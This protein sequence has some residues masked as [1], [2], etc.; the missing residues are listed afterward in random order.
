MSDNEVASVADA[1]GDVVLGEAEAIEWGAAETLI[2][3]AGFCQRVTVTNTT[4]E[5]ITWE[6]RMDVAGTITTHWTSEYT[7]DGGDTVFSGYRWNA[8]LAGYDSTTFGFCVDR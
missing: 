4:S 3:L 7:I 8:E 6:I 2:W 1:F 5:P